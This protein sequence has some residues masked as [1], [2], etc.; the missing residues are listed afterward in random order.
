VLRGAV[1]WGDRGKLGGDRV[2]SGSSLSSDDGTSAPVDTS[3]PPVLDSVVAAA[4]KSPSN[5]RP[6]LSNFSDEPLDEFALLWGN[7]LVV[8]RGLQV[9]V[10][11][12][13]A[14]LGS[15]GSD[16]VRNANPVVR[17]MS[18]DELEEARVLNSGPRSPSASDV[19]HCE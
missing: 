1:E 3:I 14:L 17:A 6:P 4:R 13:P 2:A 18:L 10:E 9:L 16:E 19:R 5:L 8:E 7:G 15:P 12:F 11:A